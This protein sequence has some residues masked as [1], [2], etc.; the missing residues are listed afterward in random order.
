MLSF[1]LVVALVCTVA[2]F[3]ALLAAAGLTR[4]VRREWR[5]TPAQRSAL[6]DLE[7]ERREAVAALVRDFPRLHPELGGAQLEKAIVDELIAL[8]RRFAQCA[9]VITGDP[10][11]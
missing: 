7:R 1:R 8:E 10:R 6:R 9:L 3:F 5:L 11:P 2:A 4:R